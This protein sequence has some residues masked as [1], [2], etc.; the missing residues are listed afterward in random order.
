M[1]KYAQILDDVTKQC[2]VG[3]GDDAEFYESIGMTQLDVE[4]STTGAWYLKGYAPLDDAKSAKNAEL[5]R[6]TDTFE[7]NVNRDIFFI[8]SLGFRCNGDK[9]T[10]YS[11]QNLI[12]FF[13]SNSQD[14]KVIY[15]DY[16]NLEQPLTKE[17]LQTLLSEQ[18][19]NINNLYAQKRAYQS[20]I[21]GAKTLDELKSLE[22]KFTMSDFTKSTY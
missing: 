8:S 22:F 3:V 10:A 17:Q 12:T 2:A 15:R 13:E 11:L 14:G 9:R 16:D 6:M 7:N 21:N 4:Q 1:L 19:T 5:L 20:L 18:F